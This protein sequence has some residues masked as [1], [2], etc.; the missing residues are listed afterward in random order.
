[1]PPVNAPAAGGRDLPALPSALVRAWPRLRDRGHG[2]H[3]GD[4]AASCGLERRRWPSGAT[5]GISLPLLG[6]D[7]VFLG[8][9]ALKFVEGGFVPV[10]LAPAIMP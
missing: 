2:D 6:I 7:L 4:R 1:M 3:G 5:L 10:L 8:S 9:N